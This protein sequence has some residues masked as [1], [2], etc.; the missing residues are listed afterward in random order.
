MFQISPLEEPDLI[1]NG[2]CGIR[3]GQSGTGTDFSPGMSAVPLKYHSDR[4]CPGRLKI[5]LRSVS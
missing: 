2:P 1:P 5:D 3:S 4:E